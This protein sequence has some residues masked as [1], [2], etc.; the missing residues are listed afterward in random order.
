MWIGLVV[1]TEKT[2]FPTRLQLTAAF[3]YY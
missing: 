3:V 2:F 1:M